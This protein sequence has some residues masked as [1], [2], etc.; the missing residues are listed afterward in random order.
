MSSGQME[1]SLSD[2]SVACLCRTSSLELDVTNAPPDL[3]PSVA[4]V[5]L[6]SSTID[7][8]YAISNQLI[9]GLARR[10]KLTANVLD[11]LLGKRCRLNTLPLTSIAS[12]HQETIVENLRKQRC[13][14]SIDISFSPCLGDLPVP[15]L[16]ILVGTPARDSLVHFAANS[17]KGA[18]GLHVLPQFSNLKHLD[19]SFTDLSQTHLRATVSSL[20]HLEHLDLS[21]TK[22]TW[23]EVFATADIFASDQL[24]Y[25]SLHSLEIVSATDWTSGRGDVSMVHRFFAKQQSLSTLD[26]SYAT[27]YSF[28][29]QFSYR[30]ASAYG[31]PFYKTCRCIL[32]CTSS[33]THLDV[34]S[35]CSLSDIT[36]L[37]LET[38][39]LDQ[40][41]FLGYVCS[42]GMGDNPMDTLTSCPHLKMTLPSWDPDASCCEQQFHP[43][44][45]FKSTLYFFDA[46]YSLPEAIEKSYDAF[47]ASGLVPLMQTLCTASRRLLTDKSISSDLSSLFRLLP[48]WDFLF[49]GANSFFTNDSWEQILENSLVFA[50]RDES[51][52]VENC[53]PNSLKIKENF[54]NHLLQLVKKCSSFVVDR[55]LLLSLALAFSLKWNTLLASKWSVLTHLF[56]AISQSKRN[57]IASKSDI[58]FQIMSHSSDVIQKS[59]KVA[60]NKKDTDKEPEDYYYKSVQELVFQGG[61]SLLNAFSVLY[62]DLPGVLIAFDGVLPVKNAVAMAEMAFESFSLHDD[63]RGLSLYVAAL[64]ALTVVAE[65]PTLAPKLFSKRV[66]NAVF[67]AV[68]RQKSMHVSYSYL[69]CLCLVHD[70][71]ASSWPTDC[72]AR[73]RVAASLASGDLIGLELAYRHATVVSLLKMAQ[74]KEFA[75]VALFGLQRLY[76]FCSSHFDYCSRHRLCPICLIKKEISFDVLCSLPAPS[77]SNMEVDLDSVAQTCKNH[78]DC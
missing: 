64:E 33:L 42:N 5:I 54:A 21:G 69:A 59:T 36:S 26:L 44:H 68:P 31:S 35:S 24:N 71:S 48:K 56:S 39:R 55:P 4:E 78:K 20:P 43:S 15:F 67:A 47:I 30:T 66:L 34:S 50:L 25:L 38:N 60:A 65:C 18:I 52:D 62:S 40:L 8:P 53:D 46:M 41:R 29:F 51:V 57:E 32:R 22:V 7:L 75:S 11:I 14:N 74:S 61:T 13:V 49:P 2:L 72:V 16:E 76:F 37:L 73:E 1:L 28:L 45:I 9:E 19:V 10:A 58:S 63:E 27:K 12:V 6:A 17:A 3:L 70:D 23:Y 77:T